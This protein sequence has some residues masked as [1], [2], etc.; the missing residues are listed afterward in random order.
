METVNFKTLVADVV[1]RVNKETGETFTSL[2][3]EQ[4]MF[5]QRADGSLT[6]VTKKASI[7]SP[8]SIEKA[9]ALKGKHLNLNIVKKECAPY[10]YPKGSGKLINFTWVAEVAQ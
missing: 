8:W 9:F 3:L 5:L 10:E 2:Q 6:A 1:E 4:D 7:P